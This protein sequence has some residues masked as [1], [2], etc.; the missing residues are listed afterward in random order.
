MER[1][2]LNGLAVYRWV[3]WVWMATVLVLARRALERP[4]VAVIVVPS[5]KLVRVS[6]CEANRW[7][8][9]RLTGDSQYFVV[10]LIESDSTWM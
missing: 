10:L 7:L 4:V 6:S 5:F 1:S 3:A 2:V 8:L 9:A